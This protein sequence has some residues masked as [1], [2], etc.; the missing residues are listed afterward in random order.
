MGVAINKTS[1]TTQPPPKN[2]K[3]PKPPGELNAFTGTKARAYGQSLTQLPD[4]DKKQGS[5]IMF[6]QNH[7][8]QTIPRHREEEPQNTYSHKTAGRQL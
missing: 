8:L 1:T 2:G 6:Y 4:C 3:Q 7:T 5:M